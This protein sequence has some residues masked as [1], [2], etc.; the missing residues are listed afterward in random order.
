MYPHWDSQ[1]ALDKQLQNEAQFTTDSGNVTCNVDILYL[2][3]TQSDHVGNDKWTLYFV[4]MIGRKI[5]DNFIGW[6]RLTNTRIYICQ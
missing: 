1:V 6:D 4:T 2:V 3:R 5:T